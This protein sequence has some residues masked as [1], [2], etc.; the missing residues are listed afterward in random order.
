MQDNDVIKVLI[1]GDIIGDGGLKKVFFNLK[2]LKEKYNVD[3]IIVNGEN[4]SGGFGI[5]PEIAENLFRSGVNVITT[6]NHVYAEHS[7]REYLTKQKY[8]LRPNN[9]S[10]L[11]EGHGY[12]IL[13]VKNEKVAVINVQGFLGMNFIV[14]NPFENVKKIVNMIKS[15]V[16][17]I[18]VDFHA[19]SNYEKESFGYFL[20]GL[21]TGVVG[22]HTHIMTQDERIL[23][24]GTAYIS[25]LGMTGSLNSV[26]GFN[27]EISLKGLLEHVSLRTETVEENVVIQGVVITSHLRT[28]RALK[29]ER[30]QK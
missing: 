2:G 11:L 26:I 24:K 22:T 9:F 21:V 7:I 28:G 5:T 10:D 15:K 18:F 23:D 16:R 12:C 4:S 14:K 3:L 25:D 20:D 6:G 19:E 17:T 27:P 1:I 29:I 30:I 13:N 8:V